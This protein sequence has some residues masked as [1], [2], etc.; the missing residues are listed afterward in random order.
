MLVDDDYDDRQLFAAALEKSGLN[1]DLFAVTDGPAAIDYLLGN[2]PFVDRAK[3]PFPDMV[4]LDLKMPQMDGFA[5]LKEIRKALGLQKLPVIVFTN[6]NFKGDVVKAYSRHA[7]AFHEKPFK[8]D[9]LVSLL[10]TVI[11]L[12]LK[13]DCAPYERQSAGFTDSPVSILP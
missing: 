13:A 3:F 2:Q 8:H 4:F 7:S 11:P 6:S 9:D 10:R 1:V 5:V 12:W